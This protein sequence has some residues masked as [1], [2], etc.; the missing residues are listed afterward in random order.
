MWGFNGLASYQIRS[1]RGT[2]DITF[3]SLNK[4]CI[5]CH[6]YQSSELDTFCANIKMSY[7]DNGESVRRE[8]LELYY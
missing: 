6:W 4:R 5:R 8:A 3:E 1:G 7:P 2:M